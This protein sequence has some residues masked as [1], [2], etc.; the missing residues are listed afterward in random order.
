MNKLPTGKPEKEPRLPDSE[1]EVMR[2]LWS[3]QKATARDVWQDLQKLGSKWTYATV[4]TL[5]QRLEMKQLVTVDKSQTSFTYSPKLS[6]QKVI[7]KRVKDLVD[8][9]YDGQPGML[10]MHLLQTHKLSKEDLSALG[11]EIQTRRKGPA[12]E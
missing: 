4:N 7:T 2:V 8:K 5:L 11:D 10:V 3:R 6:R 1:L 12:A 9:L